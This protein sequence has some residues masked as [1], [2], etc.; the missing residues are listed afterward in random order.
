M[1]T[2]E[3]EKAGST[4]MKCHAMINEGG[5]GEWRSGMLGRKMSIE[6]EGGRMMRGGRRRDTR[7][8]NAAKS[9]EMLHLH[10]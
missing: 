2:R 6:R 1:H 9:S 10:L 4:V 5:V 8:E 7:H 3:V